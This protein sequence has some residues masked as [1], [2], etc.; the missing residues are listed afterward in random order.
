MNEMDGATYHLFLCPRNAVGIPVR[1]SSAPSTPKAGSTLVSSTIGAGVADAEAVE[2][3]VVVA[4]GLI[5]EV[6]LTTSATKV[7]NTT[8]RV[9]VPETD[10]ERALEVV[11]NTVML[12]EAA[13]EDGASDDC[14][15]PL[16]GVCEVGDCARTVPARRRAVRAA[17]PGD[18]ANM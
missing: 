16:E 9:P 5:V 6:T 10:V 7:E 13:V 14:P 17:R 18:R 8:A 1:M 11:E 3:A 4:E 12:G 15:A 2:E